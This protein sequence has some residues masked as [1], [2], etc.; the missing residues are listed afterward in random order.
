MIA[1]KLAAL[2]ESFEDHRTSGMPMS[3]TQARSFGQ[4]LRDCA[5]QVS[6]MSELGYPSDTVVAF[7][8]RKR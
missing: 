1:D 6:A 4:E 7:P 3:A 8:P 2:A 5:E